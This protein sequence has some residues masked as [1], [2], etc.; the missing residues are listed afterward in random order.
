MNLLERHTE[1]LPAA[2]Y[3]RDVSWLRYELRP[4]VTVGF[5]AV[6]AESLLFALAFLSLRLARPILLPPMLVFF[7]LDD[8]IVLATIIL[9]I[10][11]IELFVHRTLLSAIIAALAFL[12]IVLLFA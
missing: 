2:A 9:I 5:I 7:L 3:L 8:G 6:P 1:S 12:A 10:A 11:V 4:V